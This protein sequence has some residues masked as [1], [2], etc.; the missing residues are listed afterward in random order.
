MTTIIGIKTNYEQE[1]IV[2]AADTQLGFYGEDGKITAQRSFHKIIYGNDWMMAHAGSVDSHYLSFQQWAQG[3]KREASKTDV[4]DAVRVAV[5]RFENSPK[6]IDPHFKKIS[7]LNRESKRSGL[8]E[9]DMHDFVLASQKPLGLYRVDFLGDLYKYLP[10]N[11]FEY[12]LFGTG[13]D[14][15]DEYISNALKRN[16]I[17]PSKI[18]ISTAIDIAIAGIDAAQ[19]DIGSSGL[20]MV[21][22]DES[23]IFPFGKDIQRD[24]LNARTNRIN[25][26]KKNFLSKSQE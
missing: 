21:I 15:V 1:G 17:N 25:K 6:L 19:A 23:G 20:D 11:E 16:I 26:I 5:D 14:Q 7:E 13:S 2:F 8:H 10:E 3:K 9:S 24:M 18:D 12:I 4:S 22:M